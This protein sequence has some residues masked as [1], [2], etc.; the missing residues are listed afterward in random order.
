MLRN[1][2]RKGW[3]SWRK[4]LD[5]PPYAFVIPEDQGDRTRVAQMVGRLLA[6]HIEVSRAQNSLTLKEGNYPAGTYV[7]RL[8]QPYRNYAV[9]LLTPQNFP[10]G[11]GQP[12]DDVSWELPAHYHLNVIPTADATIRDAALTPLKDEPHPAGN[13]SG[14]GPIFILQDTG[15]EGLFAARYRLAQFE[16]EIAEKSFRLGDTR[17]P[18]RLLD[19]ALARRSAAR[20]A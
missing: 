1:F 12:Y 9:D 10:K 5:Q 8:D 4:G 3:D 6:Q 14:S 11:G 15:Q 2:Y 16:I 19:L 7:V 13:V 18:C 20:S 17:L